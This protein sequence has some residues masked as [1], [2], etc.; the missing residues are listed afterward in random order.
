MWRPVAVAALATAHVLLVVLLPPA[1]AQ[2]WSGA[3]GFVFKAVAGVEALRAAFA[4]WRGD[5][6]RAFWLAIGVSFALLALADAPALLGAAGEVGGHHPARFLLL[7]AGNALSVY[8]AARLALACRSAGLGFEASWRLPA[9]WAIFAVIAA[10]VTGQALRR[11]LPLALA[12]HPETWADLFSYLCDGAS[13]VLMV[14]V[15]RFAIRLGGG[16]L[17]GVWWALFGANTS[18]LLFDATG[19][20]ALYS[21]AS[22]MALAAGEGFRA[23]ACLLTALAAW[24]QRD[25]VASAR[26]AR[27]A[28]ATAPVS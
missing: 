10:A 22:G 5:Y 27:A 23:L 7:V 4:L 25:L 11:E 17:A 24:H 9:T 20:L 6:M 8:G 13:F 28:A 14:P 21:S 3:A 2:G 26:A 18:W 15:L 1:A 19:A 16:R 12:G